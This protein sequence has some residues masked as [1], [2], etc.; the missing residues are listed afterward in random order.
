MLQLKNKSASIL[1]VEDNPLDTLVVKVLL[2]N[3]FNIYTVKNGY[4]ALKLLEEQ[5]IDIILMDIN[6]K[7]ANMDGTTVMKLIRKI[8]KH[9]FIRIFAVTAYAENTINFIE[10]GFDGLYVK[11]VL[12]EEIFEFISKNMITGN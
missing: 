8:E 4:D 12:K 10:Q 2:Q 6:L 3:H 11:P 7:D 9:Q 5:K 1:V